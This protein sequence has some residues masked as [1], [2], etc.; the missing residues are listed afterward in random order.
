MPRGG[1]RAGAGR[2]PDPESLRALE[3]PESYGEWIELPKSGR[4]GRVPAWPLP[5]ATN[6]AERK[7]WNRLWKSPQAIM[8]EHLDQHVQVAM[9][10]RRLIEAEDRGASSALTNTVLRMADSLGLSAIGLRSLRWKIVDRTAAKAEP[11][12][13]PAAKKKPARSSSK[14]RLEVVRDGG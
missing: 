7:L 10:V 14:A 13:K 2:P 9:Y 3:R 6:P 8:W 11:E 4:T 12:K 1:T 5:T